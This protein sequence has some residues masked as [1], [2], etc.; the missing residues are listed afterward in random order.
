MGSPDHLV[1]NQQPTLS[2]YPHV[3]ATVRKGKEEGGEKHTN[4]N[5]QDK[6]R[7][8]RYSNSALIS[9]CRSEL[10]ASNGSFKKME[11]KVQLGKVKLR[12]KV[13]SMWIYFLPFIQACQEEGSLMV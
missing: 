8:L 2:R 12:V 1:S 5:T 13:G 7:W 4:A 11:V 10:T 9:L 3:P 6:C